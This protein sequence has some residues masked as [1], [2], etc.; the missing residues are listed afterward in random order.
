APALDAAAARERAAVEATGGDRG[1]AAGHAGDVD[2][3]QAVA[4]R[5][6]AELAGVVGAP[7]LDAAC[8][9]ER[10]AVLQADR[11]RSH[12]STQAGDVHPAH[13]VTGT[14]APHLA[15]AVCAPA[16]DAAG[17]RERAAVV[18][19]GGDCGHAAA[20]AGDVDRREAS[21]GRSIAQRAAVVAPALTP[22]AL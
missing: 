2:R 10:A 13:A 21:A 14:P 3:R 22:P 11:D 5:S 1:H 16:L 20:Q 15:L 18:V 19:A 7:A 6:V 8:A 17:A 4:R 9:S 12:A